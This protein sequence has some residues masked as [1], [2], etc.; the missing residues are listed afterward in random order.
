M[1]GKY[2]YVRQKKEKAGDHA[3]WPEK[4]KLEAVTTYLATGNLTLTASMINVP[5]ETIK[6]WKTQEWWTE[7]VGQ[8]ADEEN[9]T[10][11]AK[12]KRVLDK[13]L[14]A[15]EDAIDNGETVLGKNG[16]PMRIPP[17]LRD[18][19]R[20]SADL[21]ERRN[22]MKKAS[23]LPQESIQ[24]TQDRLLKLA[25]AFAQ[26]VHNNVKE[27]KVVTQVYENDTGLPPEYSEAIQRVSEEKT[28][29]KI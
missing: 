13:S 4:K 3:W 22:I 10:L 17:R 25:D 29:E 7:V 15:V 19:H 21:M 23:T 6:R 12:L 2:V 24:S 8:I 11:D 18:V 26:F 5:R 16:R 14:A 9:I 28:D 27:E 1:A 20:V